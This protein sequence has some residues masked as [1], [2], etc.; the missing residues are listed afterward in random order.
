M[1]SKS[2]ACRWLRS[3]ARV[4]GTSRPKA[5]QLI[6][7]HRDEFLGHQRIELGSAVRKQFLD[8]G[9]PAHSI[10]VGPI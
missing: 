1:L 10:A 5:I 9:F 6:S 2:T 4:Q 3:G 8:G 7:K